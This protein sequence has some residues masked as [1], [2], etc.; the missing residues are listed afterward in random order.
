MRD[1]WHVDIE[2]ALDEAAARLAA[3]T[4]DVRARWE[5]TLAR[6]WLVQE[7]GLEGIS[8]ADDDVDRA[9]SGSQGRDY[10]DGVHLK[11]I[12][13][14]HG[15][16]QEA[17]ARALQLDR[18]PDAG[19]LAPLAAALSL[20]GPATVRRSDGATEQYKHETVPP[21]RIEAETAA[22]F[23]WLDQNFYTRPPLAL[24]LEAHHRYARVWPWEL[25][26]GLIGRVLGA[27]V[28]QAHGY[29]PLVIPVSMRQAYYQ[30][31]HY[32]IRRLEA[33]AEEAWREQLGL[34]DRFFGPAGAS[35]A[36]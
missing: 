2:V 5:A 28:Q 25:G 18:A 7:L 26:S 14:V 35:G 32:D 16:L 24:A 31:L 15:V 9:L 33:V 19:L 4:P 6:H 12:R 20:D 13:A 1:P 11:R 8:L 30:A 36:P 21:D 27:I 3:S 22:L 17:S 29:P 23:G 34:L 10:V